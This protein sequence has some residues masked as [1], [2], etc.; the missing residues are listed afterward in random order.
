MLMKV[1]KDGDYWFPVNDDS[2][3]YDAELDVPDVAMYQD[4]ATEF[5]MMSSFIESEVTKP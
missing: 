3:N 1:R 5:Y 4:I 2:A